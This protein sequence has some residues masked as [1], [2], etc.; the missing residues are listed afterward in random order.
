MKVGLILPGNI[1][2]SPYVKIYTDILDKLNISYDII[3]WN[4]DGKDKIIGYQFNYQ[5]NMHGRLSKFLPYVKYAKYIKNLVI[6]NK[7]ERLIVFGPQIAIF[8]SSFLAKNYNKKFIFDYRDL[9]IEQKWYFK[10]RFRTVLSS[11]F[12]NVISSPGFKKCLPSNFDY[13]ISHNFDINIV[14]KSLENNQIFKMDKDKISVL[15]IGGIRDFSSNVEV[16]KG[17]G[18]KPDFSIEFVGKG[19]GAV[20]LEQ[21]AKD[22]NIN[23]VTFKGYYPKEEEHIYIEG[24]T[25]LNIFYPKII[26][27]STALSN[28]FYN[29]LIYK[30]P[31]IVTN[32]SIQG[33]Y[34]EKYNLGLSLSDCDNIDLKIKDFIKNLD[35]PSFVS[36]C[37]NLLMDF[38]KDYDEIYSMIEKLFDK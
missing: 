9:S 10:S 19:N 6:K 13:L 15:T 11:S 16:L 34:V 29:A 25:F 38:L 4:R 31:M 23:N 30:R 28:R 27:H 22:N 36:R 18:N 5:G 32:N 21:Y 12:A 24:S 2:F 1:W 8:L 14:R 7:Y 37:N 26:S 20:L 3:S 33:D 17:L 35:K